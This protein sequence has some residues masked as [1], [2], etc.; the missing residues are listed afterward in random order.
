MIALILDQARHRNHAAQY[1][2][3]LKSC[4]DPLLARLIF[5]SPHAIDR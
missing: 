1:R 5:T 2:I 3:G 4:S